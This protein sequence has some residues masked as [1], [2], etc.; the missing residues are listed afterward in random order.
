MDL[1]HCCSC[2]CVVAVDAAFV[3]HVGATIA[4]FVAV[5]VVIVD[6]VSSTDVNVAAAVAAPA[7]VELL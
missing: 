2:C 1:C 3:D 6:D 5:A 7:V 4:T